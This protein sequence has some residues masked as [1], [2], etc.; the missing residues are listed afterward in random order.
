MASQAWEI[1]SAAATGDVKKLRGELNAMGAR[2]RAGRKE[3]RRREKSLRV[4]ML[5]GIG[6]SFYVKRNGFARLVRR[7]GIQTLAGEYTQAAWICQWGYGVSKRTQQAAPPAE[8][9]K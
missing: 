3:A 9:N 8:S 2:P 5:E 6:C 7:A 4:Q 1:S